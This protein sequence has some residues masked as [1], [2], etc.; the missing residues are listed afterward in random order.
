VR[1]FDPIEEHQAGL[2]HRP[3]KITDQKHTFGKD[4][5]NSQACRDLLKISWAGAVELEVEDGRFL[6][7][8]KRAIRAG[9]IVERGILRGVDPGALD[10]KAPNPFIC[11]LGQDFLLSTA[12]PWSSHGMVAPPF[13]ASGMLM[14]YRRS[15]RK[16]N[17]TVSVKE[18][19][20]EG[21]EF[22]A[23]ASE[24]IPVGA[25]LVRQIADESLLVPVPR[26]GDGLHMS[27]A[28]L[29]SYVELC[30]GIDA[31]KA[32]AAGVEPDVLHEDILRQHV[33]ET[34]AGTAP[35]MMSDRTVTLPHP[36][37]KG[38]GVF[39]CEDIKAGEIVESGLHGKIE[40]LDGDRC[41][42]VFTWNPEGKRYTDG[43][44]NNW[45]TAS[46]NAMF[47]NSDHPANCRMYRL[48]D[49]YRY[50]IVAKTDIKE[51][52]EVMHLYAS[53]SWR[54]C[55]VDDTNLPKMLPLEQS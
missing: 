33:L 41:T 20:V 14:F 42:Y 3:G 32:A 4:Y 11:K 6:T 5:F 23:V 46:A 18:S 25:P 39:A 40:G 16:Y 26:Y 44:P 15:A 10:D 43:R 28:Q 51:G 9:E 12:F 49:Q 37:W 8:A 24:D 19:P 35:V 2:V 53:S 45:A 27:D 21:F 13:L 54:K 1:R 38:F 34:R 29:D 30:R 7:T 48:F 22:D 52:E 47:Y 36:T 55:F 17:V 31:E 50:L